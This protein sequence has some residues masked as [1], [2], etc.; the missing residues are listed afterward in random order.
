M[1]AEEGIWKTLR[2]LPRD[3]VR[4]TSSQ[5]GLTGQNAVAAVS[6]GQ[7]F[8]KKCWSGRQSWA[9]VPDESWLLEPSLRGARYAEVDGKTL[10][11]TLGALRQFHWGKGE[12]ALALG[13]H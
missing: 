5:Q 6:P 7:R 1:V 9:G 3:A 10:N 4:T 11:A 2:L 8:Q 12:R 13:W